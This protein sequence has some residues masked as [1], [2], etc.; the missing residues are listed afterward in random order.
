MLGGGLAAAALF[1]CDEIEGPQ[2]PP[3][4]L[5][6]SL[7]RVTF[8]YACAG[9]GDAQ[10][11]VDADLA[12]LRSESPFPRLGVG[13]R[14]E[15]T[16]VST[17]FGAIEVDTASSAVLSVEEDGALRAREA[18]L[19]SVVALHEG[20]PLDFADVELVEPA[21]LEIL[22][23][24]PQGSFEGV[25]LDISNGELT[26]D[27]DATFTFKFRAIVVDASGALLAGDYPCSWTSS[28]ESVAEITS[29]PIDNIV[30]VVS[31]QAGSA[32]VTVEYAG[33]TAT[34]GIEVGT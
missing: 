21:G 16:G 31:G 34:I 24:T 13:S 14:F 4:E 26:A 1:G 29:D 6:G 27:V 22:Q 9:P 33:F 7:G 20:V 2:Q 15:L 30:T 11:D 19:V 25:D 8:T 10:C 28:D 23:A 17:D 5:L 12:P 18:G 3:V 32:V